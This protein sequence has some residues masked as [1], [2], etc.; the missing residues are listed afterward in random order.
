MEFCPLDF[1]WIHYSWCSNRGFTL[2][3]VL[4]VI[5]IIG[6]LSSVAVPML[7]QNLKRWKTNQWARMV[8]TSHH[9]ARFHALS[10]QREVQIRYHLDNSDEKITF[11]I[12]PR[13]DNNGECNDDSWKNLEEM[14]VLKADREYVDLWSVGDK[15]AGEACLVYKPSG[16]ISQPR[17]RSS[18][19]GEECPGSSTEEVGTGVHITWVPNPDKTQES[20][21]CKWNTIVHPSYGTGNPTLLQYGAYPSSSGPFQSH[22]ISSEPS[23]MS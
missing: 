2:L 14:N 13:L 17:D 7:G 9:T 20:E 22:D 1:A 5:A 18:A 23:C 12:C 4:V 21:H 19:S 8:L 16:S 15:T 6:L 11:H 3:E 10:K